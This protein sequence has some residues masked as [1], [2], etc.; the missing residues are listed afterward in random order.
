VIGS[1]RGSGL[2]NG[3]RPQRRADPAV[4][5]VRPGCVEAIVMLCRRPGDPLHHPIEHD[6]VVFGFIEAESAKSFSI[7]PGCDRTSV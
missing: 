3:T 7:R 6:L 2:A 1:G 4:R 5:W